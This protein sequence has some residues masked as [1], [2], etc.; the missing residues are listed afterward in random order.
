MRIDDWIAEKI[1]DSAQHKAGEAMKVGA[2]VS[3]KQL[4][5]K[6]LSQG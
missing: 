1:I 2:T 6:R 3:M 5:E 4:L